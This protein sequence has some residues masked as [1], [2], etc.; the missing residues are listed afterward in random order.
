MG[1][2]VKDRVKDRQRRSEKDG[3][4]PRRRPRR[5]SEKVFKRNLKKEKILGRNNLSDSLN[6]KRFK[7]LVVLMMSMGSRGRSDHVVQP[8]VMW[9]LFRKLSTLGALCRT[10]SWQPA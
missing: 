10:I 2:L 1:H 7:G 4:N 8:S 3:H 9:Q 5:L 6:F